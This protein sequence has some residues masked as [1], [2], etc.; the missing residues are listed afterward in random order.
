MV[1]IGDAM[2]MSNPERESITPDDRQT[3]VQTLSGNVVQ[4]FGQFDNGEKVSMSLQF[5]ADNWAKVMAYWKARTMV[6]IT[7]NVSHSFDA[8]VLIKQY[9][10][11]D[12]FR[13]HITATL[14]FWRV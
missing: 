6:T 5:D 3:I 8:R 10:Y 11:V 4:D 13:D 12:W 1:K 7:D 9:A 2:S 14:E